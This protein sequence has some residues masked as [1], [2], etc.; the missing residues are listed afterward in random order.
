M[1]KKIVSIDF[2][3]GII[4]DKP[5]GYEQILRIHGFECHKLLVVKSCHALSLQSHLKRDETWKVLSGDCL[6]TIDKKTYK[7]PTGTQWY[8]KKKVKH[9]IEAIS[10]TVIEEWSDNYDPNDI[11]R[12]DDMYGRAKC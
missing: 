7:A 1:Q 9:R 10:D 12:W 2:E 4:I 8:I 6:I 11:I 3:D 5:W